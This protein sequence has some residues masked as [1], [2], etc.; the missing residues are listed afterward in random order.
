[1]QILNKTGMFDTLNIKQI[2]ERIVG[3]GPL[4]VVDVKVSP[5]GEIELLIDSDGS[6]AIDDCVALSRAVEAEFDRDEEDFSLTVA[7]AGVGQPLKVHRQYR[8]LV[9][10]PVEVV[11]KNGMK[12]VAELRDAAPDSITLAWTEKVAVEGKK[13]KEEVERVEEYPLA[14]VKSTAEHLDFK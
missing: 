12:I 1:M 9:G 13:R 7:S 4:F 3:D 5:A 10:K 14:E 6:V 8:K 11:L 2:A